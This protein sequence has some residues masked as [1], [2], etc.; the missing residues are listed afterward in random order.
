MLP[1]DAVIVVV[2]GATGARGNN[3]D[4]VFGNDSKPDGD[5]DEDKDLC[6]GGGS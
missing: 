5:V 6:E 1:P 3:A 4:V 2:M